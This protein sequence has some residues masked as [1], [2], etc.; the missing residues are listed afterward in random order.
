MS[1]VTSTINIPQPSIAGRIGTGIGKG[2]A[3]QLPEEITRG[4]LS[5]GLQQI[6]NQ[7]N[8]DPWQAFTQFASTPGVTP[9]MLQSGGELLK[10]RARGQSLAN[11]QNQPKPNPFQNLKDRQ[12]TQATPGSNIPSLTS[13][14]TSAKAQQGFIPR[15]EDEKLQ[16]AGQ[17]YNE[18]PGLFGNDPQK[19]I[20]YED[21]ADA[22]NQAI[23]QANQTKHA[24]LTHT[25]DNV[26]ERLGKQYSR[27]NGGNPNVPA[28]LY[29]KI[30]DEAIQATK[31][32]KDGGGGLTEQQASKQFSDKLNDAERTFAK[33][34]EITGPDGWLGGGWN[35]TQRKPAETLRT[36]KNTQ[37]EMEK[38][39]QTDNYAKRLIS[40]AKVS[41]MLG[42]AIAEP[43]SRVPQLGS[44]LRGI[45][46]G[47]AQNT[48]FETVGNVAKTLEVAPQLAN[49]VKNN[50]KA[51]PLAIAYE[52][53]KKGLDPTTWLKYL[54][55][56][57]N[58]LNLGTRQVEQASS[59]INLVTPWNDWWLESFTGIE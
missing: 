49:V 30:E 42:Y 1:K 15:T 23:A 28:E 22:T 50:E 36:M 7:P 19:A 47:Q 34:D 25:Q 33:V 21:R 8:Q 41:P 54:T 58:E 53:Q 45:E 17:R 35:I 13:E 9:Q 6:G 55:D 20:E 46:P 27:L 44:I 3:E 43:V 5:H 4:R 37:Q 51:S 57:A 31:P 24:N 56:H 52:L 10:Q 14:E 11:L 12:G 48:L 29:T 26:V 59:P 39:G 38:L 32:K 40:R 2:L 18:N 16:S